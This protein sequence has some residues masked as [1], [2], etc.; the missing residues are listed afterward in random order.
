MTSI[1]KIGMDVHSTNYTLY[2]IEPK[3]G[4]K[5]RFLACSKVASDY[6]NI[7]SFIRELKK[8][9]KELGEDKEYDIECGYEAGCLGYSLYRD[10]TSAGI[11]CTILAPTTMLTQQRKRIK[12]DTRDAEMIAQC[13]AHGGYSFVFVPTEEDNAVKEYLRMKDD[14]KTALKKIK[15]QINALCLKHGYNYTKTKW[16]EMHLKWLKKIELNIVV[17][18]TLEE[19]LATYSWLT[20]QIERCD[21]RIEEIALSERYRERVKKLCCFRGIKTATALL[22]L[23]E[24]GDFNRFPNASALAAFL[25]TVPGETSSGESIHRTGITK[26]G[27]STL[28]RT[29]VEAVQGICKGRVGYKSKALRARQKGN[30]AETIAYADRANIRLLSRFYKFIRNG[31]KRNIA[32]TAITRE[33]VCFI[34]GMMTENTELK[35][36]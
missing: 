14:H 15:Q 3:L 22:L 33:I 16:T 1:I 27:N 20:S 6:K 10:L 24:I 23:V 2:A 25:G 30:T 18:E 34:W 36:A 29:L 17:R 26:A 11:K 8:Q 7:L 31:K 9:L 32:V 19:Y 5:D 35:A 12:T 4:K 28:R 13:L 21:E